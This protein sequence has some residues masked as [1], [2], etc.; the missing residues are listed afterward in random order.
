MRSRMRQ[1][2]ALALLLAAALAIEGLRLLGLASGGVAEL[3]SRA[4]FLLAALLLAHAAAPIS[5]QQ[6]DWDSRKAI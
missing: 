4:L 6:I 5:A 3:V 1:F 2:V